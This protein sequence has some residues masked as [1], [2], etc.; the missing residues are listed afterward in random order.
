MNLVTREV[1]GDLQLM[2]SM[3]DETD[4]CSCCG[5][6]GGGVRHVLFDWYKIHCIQLHKH[7]HCVSI[8]VK[9]CIV[10]VCN[11][12]LQCIYKYNVQVLHYITDHKD[13]C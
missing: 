13:A 3:M 7:T 8:C 12:K 5:T 4:N 1:A 10:Q 6:R 2:V 9:T 11:E